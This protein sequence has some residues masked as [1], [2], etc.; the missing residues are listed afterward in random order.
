LGVRATE[1]QLLVV[2]VVM[3]LQ[4]VKEEEVEQVVGMQQV[5]TMVEKEVMVLNMEVV[6]EV[7]VEGILAIVVVRVVMVV[8]VE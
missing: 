6:V 4:L 2:L 1:E 5:C 3:A 7:V 8:P